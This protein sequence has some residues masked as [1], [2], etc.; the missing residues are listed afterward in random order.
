MRLLIS[1]TALLAS[2]LLGA[3]CSLVYGSELDARQCKVDDD[4]QAAATSLETPLVCRRN[5]CQA[6]TCDENTAC[7]SGSMCADGVCIA[8]HPDAGSDAGP[9]PVACT[10]DTDCNVEEHELCGLD[11]FCYVK[12][13]CLDDDADWPAAPA[14]LDFQIQLQD[15]SAPNLMLSTPVTVSA[16]TSSDP[17]CSRPIIANKDVMISPEKVLTVPFSGL[18]SSGFL[19]T[20]RVESTVTDT[21]LLPSYIHFSAENPLVASYKAPRPMQLIPTSRFQNLALFTGITASPDSAGLF[22]HIFDCGGRPASEVALSI[23][24]VPDTVKIV[25]LQGAAN[26]VL[27]SNKTTADGTLIVINLPPNRVQVFTL[28]DETT[29]RLITDTLNFIPRGP[30]VNLFMYYPR[31]STVERWTMQAQRLGGIQ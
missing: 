13:G 1:R 20:I 21:G 18:T 9:E 12:W 31:Q 28:V 7:P 4:C 8:E 2:S 15:I 16:C 5:A 27:G 17:T 6:P 19:G 26:L 24:N 22:M 10:L 11:G 14:S 30:A 29:G 25:P 23:K 3:G